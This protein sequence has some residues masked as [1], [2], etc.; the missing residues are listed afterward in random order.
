MVIDFDRLLIFGFEQEDDRRSKVFAR[1]E[2]GR[3]GRA[4]QVGIARVEYLGAIIPNGICVAFVFA[5]VCDRHC[6]KRPSEDSVFKTAFKQVETI[7][8]LCNIGNNRAIIDCI[9][10]VVLNDP[11]GIENRNFITH[12]Q[13]L[14]FA[15]RHVQKGD[16][17]PLSDSAQ[18]NLHAFAQ[19]GI[20]RS[21]RFVK[22]H[23]F[24]LH[25]KRTG[26]RHTLFLAAG[27]LFRTAIFQSGKAHHLYRRFYTF[28][29]LVFWQ[30]LRA[31]TKAERHIFENRKVRKQ[32]KV[33]EH[34]PDATFMCG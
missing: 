11:A 19:I 8:K 3:Q 6:P 4:W 13:R 7:K 9:W 21:E 34:E 30:R 31:V 10:G 18:F 33:L 25:H 15:S 14:G 26:Q 2:P 32:R 20:K 12:R 27:Y 22:Q 1:Q 23:Q 17:E 16:I 28:R 5:W 24:G 29:Y